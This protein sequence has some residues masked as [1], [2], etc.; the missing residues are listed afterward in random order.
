MI[1]DLIKWVVPGLATVLGGTT[2]CLAMTSG[3]IALDLTARTASVISAG[4]FD[5][6]EVSVDGRDITLSGTTTDSAMVDGAAKQLAKVVGIRSVTTAVT[7]APLA[8]PY[9]L[10]ASIDQGVISLNGGVPDAASRR[11]LLNTAGVQQGDLPLRSGM[12]DRRTWLAGATFAVDQLRY[13]DQ[14]SASITDLTVDLI[15]RASSQRAFRDLLIV[16][17]AGPPAGVTMGKASIIPPLMS[18]YEWRA[19]FDGQRISINGFVP[20]DTLAES[21]RT[22]DLSG[23]TVATGLILGSGE[24]EGFAELSQMLIQQLSRLEYGSV[25]IVDGQS[26]LEGAPSSI[27]VAQGI[28]DTLEPSG[29]IVVLEP[30]RIDDY[31]ITATRQPGGVVVF[32]GYAPDEATREALGQHDGADTQFLKLGRGAPERF[33]SGVDFGLSALERMSEGRMALRDNVLTLTGTANS[34]ADYDAL[35]AIAAAEAPQ[36]IVLSP[37]DIRAP[38]VASYEWSAE[39]AASGAIALAGFVPSPQEKADLL[40][41]AGQ[42][43]TEAL[44]YASGAPNNFTAS[45]KTGLALLKW[46]REG[47]VVFDGSG[48]TITGTANTAIDKGAIDAEFVASRLA[49]AGWSMAVAEPLPAIPRVE[50]YLWSAT[51]ADDGVTLMGHVPNQVDKDSLTTRAG[52]GTIDK[53]SIGSGAPEDFSGA[54]AAGLDAVLGLD[55][56]EVSFD[57]TQWSLGG[58]AASEAKR[59]DVLATLTAAH[60]I[61]N[62]TVT[63]TAAKPAPV[64]T[65]PY[66]WSATKSS[67][68]TVELAGLL[69]TDTLKRSAAARAG[70][71]LVDETTVDPSA[72][73]GFAQ[74]VMA[75]MDAIGLLSEGQ[76]SFDGSTWSISGIAIDAATIDTALA[77]A[78]TPLTSWALDLRAPPAVAEPVAQPPAVTEMPPVS[79]ID[80]DYAFSASKGSDGAVIFSGQLPDDSTMQ[81]LLAIADGADTAAISIAD[82][83]PDAFLAM[84][85]TGLE[86]MSMLAEAQLDFAAGAWSLRGTAADDAA[87]N[88]ALA[89]IEA[90]PN[91][92][93][94]NTSIAVTQAT[95]PPSEPQPVPAEA[96]V[97]TPVDIAACADPVAAF[98]AR[99]AILFQSGAAIIAS[100]S[101][102][103]LDE[104]ASDLAACPDA[105]VHVEGHTDSDGDDTL[106]MA[107]S[108]ARAESVIDALVSRG[109]T[110]ARLYAV[111]FGESAP[112][113]DN[114][115]AD[116]KRLNRRIV[117]TVQPEHY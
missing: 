35:L 37:L 111:G 47:R 95:P 87:R 74:D 105:V 8:S 46:L 54:A 81:A 88:A 84:S 85:E 41:T 16:L 116:G 9:I 14:G 48:W 1:R 72:P 17:R 59:D 67:D 19:T 28:V 18:P 78:A 44:A 39:K 83:A 91:A 100:E 27:E 4:G 82:G 63:V 29:T 117:V 6:A 112:V 98:S 109:V 71:R 104:L 32:D 15:G 113:A 11:Q 26:T 43:S 101:Q 103:A 108:V 3:D 7:L 52:D 42:S 55:E 77:N 56:G 93:G 90:G 99:N 65:T 114:E 69:P 45:A 89:A 30:P 76:V 23:A 25:S 49:A 70:G 33:Q 40:A 96:S 5:W 92:A 50:P 62:W 73:D 115:T 24:P 53:M 64:A 57:G 10:Q 58:T 31:W 107:L 20:D 66:L 21:Y 13:L 75:A 2:L 86:A 68:G 110:A 80:P 36:G 51:R 34:A 102:S 38:R 97:P 79:A 94:W 106:N 22:A 60:D 61:A 12:S